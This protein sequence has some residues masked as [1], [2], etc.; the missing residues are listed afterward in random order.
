M[1]DDTPAPIHHIAIHHIATV[2]DW[3]AAQ[4][5]GEYRR[6]TRDQSLDDV[7]FIHCSTSAQWPETLERF[8]AD[9]TEDLLLLTIDPAQV[10]AELR[11]EDGFP[12]IYGPLPI[13]AVTRVRPLR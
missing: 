1:P 5:A 9:C 4:Q 3:E 13:A 7:G 6:S 11:V 2:P 8:Y 12:H 10:T